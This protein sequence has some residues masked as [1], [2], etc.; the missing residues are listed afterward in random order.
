[1]KTQVRFFSDA[2]ELIATI[3]PLLP[4]RSDVRDVLSHIES[5]EGFLYLIDLTSEQVSSLRLPS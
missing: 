5:K 1:V 4:G 3:N 2:S